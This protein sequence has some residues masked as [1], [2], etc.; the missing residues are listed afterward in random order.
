MN[1][2]GLERDVPL[3]VE[4]V[5][6]D[7]AEPLQ[8]VVT[9]DT[10]VDRICDQIDIVTPAVA[11]PAQANGGRRLRAWVLEHRRSRI[12]RIRIGIGNT[13]AY[14]PRHGIGTGDDAQLDN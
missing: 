1:I 10:A 5:V 13:R 3:I 12:Q 9:P 8:I 14:V 11:S 4:L 7:P 6:V 2:P